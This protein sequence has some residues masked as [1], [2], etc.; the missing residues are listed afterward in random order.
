MCNA[1]GRKNGSSEL[2]A[3][4]MD[5]KVVKNGMIAVHAMER[6]QEGEIV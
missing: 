5:G 2:V 3:P 4:W 6:P 1:H